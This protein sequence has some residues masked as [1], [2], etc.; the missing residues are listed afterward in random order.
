MNDMQLISA[1]DR[2][3]DVLAE[4]YFAGHIEDSDE[5]NEIQ[6]EVLNEIQDPDSQ[7]YSQFYDE[8]DNSPDYHLA[9]GSG[10]MTHI[11]EVRQKAIEK[12]THA[13]FRRKMQELQEMSC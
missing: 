1:V 5:F 9:L 11:I 7:I 10:A 8:L 12:V 2:R 13:Q 3:D 4:H 6:K